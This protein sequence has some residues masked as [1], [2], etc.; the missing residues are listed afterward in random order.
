MTEPLITVARWRGLRFTRV[1]FCMLL[2]ALNKIASKFYL[3]TILPFK[4]LDP[5]IP[6]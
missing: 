3:R 5:V 4:D 1:D 2:L 6:V